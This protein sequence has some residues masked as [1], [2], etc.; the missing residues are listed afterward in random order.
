M[1]YQRMLQT[2]VRKT[3]NGPLPL[4]TSRSTRSAA[5]SLLLSRKTKTYPP[6]ETIDDYKFG[7][8]YYGELGL[9][10]GV[11]KIKRPPLDPRF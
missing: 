10:P 7:S 4:C 9:G 6:T 5:I 8:G 1:I 3:G 11:N 2:T